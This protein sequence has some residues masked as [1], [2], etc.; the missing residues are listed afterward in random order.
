M[1]DPRESTTTHPVSAYLA[2][3]VVLEQLPGG[4][5][6]WVVTLSQPALQ[7]VCPQV[8]THCAAVAVSAA[9]IVLVTPCAVPHE[10]QPHL[11]GMN[12]LLLLLRTHAGAGLRSL[13]VLLAPMLSS[14]LR[15]SRLR[16]LHSCAALHEA[17]LLR[18][19][20]TW[21]SS[22]RCAC[23]WWLVAP[24]WQVCAGKLTVQCSQRQ[25]S[26][27]VAQRSRHLRDACRQK[28]VSA[29]VQLEQMCTQVAILAGSRWHRPLCMATAKKPR[30]RLLT[31]VS[32]CAAPCLATCCVDLPQPALAR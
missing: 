25:F 6:V 3:H 5:T 7:H 14:R 29:S 22:S 28:G 8:P 27:G 9:R 13:S 15:Q 2:P 10:Q 31:T 23:T 17:W 24:A 32:I 12:A 21:C 20:S 19:C 26:Q 16:L 18:C 30:W 4:G 11:A 1:H